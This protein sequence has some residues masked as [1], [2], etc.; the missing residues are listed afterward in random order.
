VSRGGGG[1][2]N[3]CSSDRAGFN[4]E[5]KKQSSSNQHQPT[6][7]KIKS[8]IFAGAHAFTKKSNYTTRLGFQSAG[9]QRVERM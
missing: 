9:K 5:D 4:Q 6:E 8:Q 2:D 7:I 1:G 3:V